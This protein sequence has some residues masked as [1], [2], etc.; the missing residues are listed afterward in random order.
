MIS[1][2]KKEPEKIEDP[3]SIKHQ[4]DIALKALDKEMTIETML[5]KEELQR[6]EQ[7]SQELD[8]KVELEKKKEDCILK[9]IKEREIENQFNLRKKGQAEEITNMKDIAK[10]Q[11][12]LRRD[13]LK[14]RIENLKRKAEHKNEMKK[15]QIMTI[16]M[17]VAN[18]LTQA[19]RKG[20]GQTCASAVKSTDEWKNFCSG[21]FI[22]NYA[23]M[24]S[25]KQEKDR[26]NYCCEKEFGDIYI[27]ERASCIE[28]HCG[29]KSDYD[30]PGRWVYK[31]DIVTDSDGKL[32]AS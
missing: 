6:E 28:K 12:K 1:K 14:K 32:L 15:Q 8:Y 19:Y 30:K 9:A 11:I 3:L 26:C 13:Y 25:C 27:E 31:K 10:K 4:G 17:E 21:Y 7:E 20:S 18:T 22:D 5:E 24:E 23:E 2:R 16:R 29:V